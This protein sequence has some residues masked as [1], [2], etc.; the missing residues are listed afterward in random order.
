MWLDLELRDNYGCARATQFDVLRMGRSVSALTFDALMQQLD[1]ENASFSKSNS[2]RCI[3]AALQ[4]YL[5]GHTPT[6]VGCPHEGGKRQ[7][8][9]RARMDALH[10]SGNVAKQIVRGNPAFANV[11]L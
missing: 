11:S 2:E 10:E 1:P 9:C 7:L 3:T 4:Q 6:Y 5:A 8:V